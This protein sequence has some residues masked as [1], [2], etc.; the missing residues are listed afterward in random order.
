MQPISSYDAMIAPADAR[1]IMTCFSR[2]SMACYSPS[3][4]CPMRPPEIRS[5][6]HPKEP[7]PPP[8]G[9]HD[10]RREAHLLHEK[11]LPVHEQS[12]RRADEHAVERTEAKP[13]ERDDRKGE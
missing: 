13:R 6:R 4:S 5:R 2:A 3:S 1:P 11:P 7:P 10:G 12:G 9:W 8:G